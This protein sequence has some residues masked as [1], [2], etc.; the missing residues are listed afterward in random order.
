[1]GKGKWYVCIGPAQGEVQGPRDEL[2]WKWLGLQRVEVGHFR[3]QKGRR[4]GLGGAPE[5][6]LKLVLEYYKH[7][8]AL[9]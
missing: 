9:A 6:I 4:T 7:A 3:A 1:M 2:N 5:S 8:S